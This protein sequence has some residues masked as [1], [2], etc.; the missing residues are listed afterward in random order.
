MNHRLKLANLAGALVAVAFAAGCA[1][2]GDA[3]AGVDAYAP[4]EDEARRIETISRE[5]VFSDMHAHPSRFHRANVEAIE[6]D[7]IELYRR[8]HLSLVVANISS[9]MAY[10]GRYTNRDGTEVGRGRY[11]P[12]P[13]E[14]YALA[15]DRL[16]RIVHTAALDRALLADTPADAL[17]AQAANELAL[18]P[19]LEGGDAL[20]GRID[21]L[22]N[23]HRDGL[24]LIQLIHFRDNEIGHMQTWPATG[25]L[26]VNCAVLPVLGRQRE[27]KR[28]A[29]R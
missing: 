1:S 16:Q 21:N 26:V 17:R 13:G 22:R 15:A 29:G 24:R 23:L 7:E 28:R 25:S 18:L 5:Y 12:A 8:Q 6:A 4:T 10:S 20:E 27:M 19:A 14:V 11:K 2:S 9:D 3:T